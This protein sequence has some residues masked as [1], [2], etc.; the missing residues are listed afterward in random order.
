MLRKGPISPRNKSALPKTRSTDSNQ[1]DQNLG[2][3]IG[4]DLGTTYPGVGVQERA[5][6][7]LTSK[8][9]LP[10]PTHSNAIQHRSVRPHRAPDLDLRLPGAAAGEAEEPKPSASA[11]KGPSL[12]S[13]LSPD[14]NSR[15]IRHLSG[16]SDATTY[17]SHLSSILDPAMIVTPVTLVRTAPGRQAAVQRVALRG[18][19]NARVVR[20]PPSGPLATP[21]PEP[22]PIIPPAHHH[23]TSVRPLAFRRRPQPEGTSTAYGHPYRPENHH[24]AGSNGSQQ[25]R[26]PAVYCHRY[27]THRQPLHPQHHQVLYPPP[28]SHA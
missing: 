21:S 24:N 12:G 1:A 8:S 19:E 20:L 22:A 5:T 9:S 4:I 3:V 13:H 7:L 6:S 18:Q 17:D 26:S 23:P 11:D 27:S 16:S 10:S 14:P 2:S 25:P 15:S 28:V